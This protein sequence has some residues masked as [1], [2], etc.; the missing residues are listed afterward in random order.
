MLSAFR[1]PLHMNIFILTLF[2]DMFSGPFDFSIVKRAINEKKVKLEIVNLRDFA[3][4]SYGT[5]DDH[6]Y[7]GG[8]GMILKV[9]VIDRT[10]QSI[11]SKISS[12]EKTKTILLDARGTTYTQKIAKEYTQIDNLIIIC[13][14]YEGV[15]ERVLSLVDE[16]ISI[17]NFV[18][19]GGEIPAMV[20]M[21][22]ITRL[23]PGVLKKAN[24]ITDESFSQDNL[25]YPQYTKP[26]E[27]NGMKVPEV[28]L[29]GN[30]SKI[31]KWKEEKTKKIL[32]KKLSS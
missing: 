6:P 17:G 18:L 29:S 10:L 21:D 24:A 1:F 8:V 5:V 14:H 23:I 32:L 12:H 25:E 16:S 4:D 11:K 22:S 26:Q 15:D 27:Y 9:D 31:S 30:H 13:G 7:G 20:L 3:Q 2:P 28:L 19:T